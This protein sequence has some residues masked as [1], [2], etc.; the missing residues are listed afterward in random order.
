MKVK[1][2]TKNEAKLRAVETALSEYEIFKGVKVISI[3]VSSGVSDQPMSMRETVLG[4]KNRALKAF[5]GCDYSIGLENGFVEVPGFETGYMDLGCCAIYDGKKFHLGLSSGF[6]LPRIVQKYVN[7]GLNM[8][9]AAIKAG[10][11]ENSKIGAENGVISILS[12]GKIRREDYTKQSVK[13]ALI[14]IENAALYAKA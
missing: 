3:A 12:K 13:M 14:Q 10:L 6:E 1:V 11:T 5:S 8:T 2:G 7:E 9:D 4:A